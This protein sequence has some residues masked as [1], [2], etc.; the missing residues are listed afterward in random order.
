MDTCFWFHAH[1]I[2]ALKVTCSSLTVETW[3]ERKVARNTENPWTKRIFT[4][5]P[6]VFLPK[7]FLNELTKSFTSG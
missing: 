3:E 2:L 6:L 1:I 5:S 7:I 4:Y